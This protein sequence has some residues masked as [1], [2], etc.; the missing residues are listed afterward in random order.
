V[1]DLCAVGWHVCASPADVASS[2]IDGCAGS[3]DAPDSFFAARISGPGCGVCATGTAPDCTGADCRV[4]CAMTLRTTNDV[5]GCGTLGD[6]P[7]AA[8]CAPLDRFSNNLCTSL[9]G[10]WSCTGDPSGTREALDLTKTG[11]ARGGVLCCRD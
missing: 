8:T 1:A 7:S 6:A 2:S 9:G 10:P 5:F 11:P 4:G 3:H